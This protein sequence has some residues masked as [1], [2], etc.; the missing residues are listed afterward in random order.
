MLKSLLGSIGVK[1]S[2]QHND[3]NSDFLLL[4]NLVISAFFLSFCN[5]VLYVAQVGSSSL[6]KS[7]VINL[8]K[9]LLKHKDW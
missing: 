2:L 1:L 3:L 9:Y 6:K 8:S 4:K 5:I 7:L